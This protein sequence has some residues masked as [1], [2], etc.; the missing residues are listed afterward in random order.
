MSVS[1]FRDDPMFRAIIPP[2]RPLRFSK[3]GDA[4]LEAVYSTHFVWPGKGL[5]HS[6][7]AE[8]AP[9]AEAN[10][11]AISSNTSGSWGRRSE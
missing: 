5:F 8:P 11:H 10:D 6:V 1:N 3:T 9:G 4:R 7:R 2:K